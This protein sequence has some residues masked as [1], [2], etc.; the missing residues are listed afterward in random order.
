MKKVFLDQLVVRVKQES[1]VS[2]VRPVGAVCKVPLELLDLL[3]YLVSLVSRASPALLG[4]L[5]SR[6]R[7]ADVGPTDHQ[8]LQV[9]Q[10][11]RGLVDRTEQ[12]E[13]PVKLVIRVAE[14]ILAFQVLM[15]RMDWS[16]RLANKAGQE[17]VVSKDRKAMPV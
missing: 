3:V 11:F 12:R 8:V 9:L 16:D 14:E 1:V 10:V 2:R 15:E 13:C 5:D 6:G 17:Q 7:L 4:S